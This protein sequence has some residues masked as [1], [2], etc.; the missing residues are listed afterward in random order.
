MFKGV[1]MN[2]CKEHT[3]LPPTEPAA[4]RTDKDGLLPARAVTL[5]RHHGGAFFL[6]V[7]MQYEACLKA[8]CGMK[9]RETYLPR[10]RPQ[11]F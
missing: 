11:A 8:G 10:S 1:S 2:E 9:R 4:S 6:C 5:E 7:Q 3:L